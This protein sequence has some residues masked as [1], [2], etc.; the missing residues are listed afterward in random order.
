MSGQ[1]PILAEQDHT[2]LN[3][4]PDQNLDDRDAA[5]SE[6]LSIP[7][8]SKRQLA[9]LAGILFVAYVAWKLRQHRSITPEEDSPAAEPMDPEME[10]EVVQDQTDP[11]KADESVVEGMKESG[12]L[13]SEEA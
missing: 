13:D 11:L 4:D 5:G 10:I 7:S 12:R 1:Q 9:I 2:N 8:I 6:G 3:P